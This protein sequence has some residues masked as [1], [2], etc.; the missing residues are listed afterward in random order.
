MLG[1]P[2]RQTRTT[3]ALVLIAAGAVLGAGFVLICD[4]PHAEAIAV[5]D[6]GEGAKTRR[7]RDSEAPRR[8]FR[9]R[10]DEER[11]DA[12]LP[13]PAQS[14]PPQVTLSEDELTPTPELTFP[15]TGQ[16]ATSDEQ[17]PLN[18]N[19]P[20][21][22][23]PGRVADEPRPRRGRW[24]RQGRAARRDPRVPPVAVA[25]PHTPIRIGGGEGV[26][27]RGE[28]GGGTQFG[29]GEGFRV[30]GDHGTRVQFGGGEG[31]RV[32]GSRG[33]GVQFGGGRGAV[34]GPV[35]I[36]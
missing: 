22:I 6:D 25:T 16:Q 10:R 14:G 5:A 4:R 7:R 20:E 17:L 36:E 21:T 13:P 18:I 28:G 23:P 19:V 8:I 24:G 27:I 35:G 34:F 29:G 3:Q 26:N 32:N 15:T 31:F 30:D 33:W 12:E 1:S 2:L 11:Q 9:Q